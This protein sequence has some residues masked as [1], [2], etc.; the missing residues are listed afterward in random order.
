MLRSLKD[1][2]RYKVSATD[3]DVGNVAGF[4]MADAR[5]AVRYLVVATGSF[6]ERRQLLIAPMA[7][8]AV[9]DSSARLRLTISVE[10]LKNAPS[11]NLDLPVSQQDEQR[12]RGEYGFY[13]PSPDGAG[14][15]ASDRHLRSVKDVTGH[16]IEGTD[17]SIGHVKDFV[18]DDETWEIRYLFVAT[19]NWWLGKGVLVAPEWATRISWL[20]RK[21]YLGLTRG[22]VKHSPKWSATYPVE[23]GYEEQLKLHYESVPGGLSRDRTSPAPANGARSEVDAPTDDG[24]DPGDVERANAAVAAREEAQIRAAD[25]AVVRDARDGRLP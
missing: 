5:W 12:Y 25:D 23:R 24:D 3:G 4:L 21:I 8:R 22:A 11:V 7:F 20:D 10:T 6:F 1:L 18:V 13:D 2:E 9:D 15:P 16:H 17:G 14:G 19:N